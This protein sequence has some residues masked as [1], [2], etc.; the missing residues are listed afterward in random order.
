MAEVDTIKSSGLF[1]EFIWIIIH[2]KQIFVLHTSSRKVVKGA[3]STGKCNLKEIKVQKK[4]YQTEVHY[5][6]PERNFIYHL[7]F[8][9][10]IF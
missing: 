6:F 9:L 4:P 1:A 5:F 3:C 8:S 2:G 7:G 10:N